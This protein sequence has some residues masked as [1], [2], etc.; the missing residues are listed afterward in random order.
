MKM[1]FA[2]WF[3]GRTPEED[4]DEPARFAAPNVSRPDEPATTMPSRAAGPAQTPA[5]TR[6]KAPPASGFDPYNSGSFERRS[7]WERVSRR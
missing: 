5:K 6:A 3:G 4:T 2:K 1:W 7:A